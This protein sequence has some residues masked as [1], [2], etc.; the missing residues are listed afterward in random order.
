MPHRPRRR[1]FAPHLWLSCF[2]LAAPL[3]AGVAACSGG[4]GDPLAAKPYDATGQ[5]AYS[6]AD[7][8]RQVDPDK[9]L[10]VT[11]KGSGNKI[12]DVTAT[13]ATGRYVR[14][15]LN[16]DGTQ[17]HSTAAL[18][19]G[20]HYT[21]RVSTENADG[22]QGRQTVGFDTAPGDN[23]LRVRFGPQGGTYGVGQP[24]IAELNRPV[25]DPAARAAV[26]GALRVSSKPA[27]TGAW[28]WVD[29]RTL[30]Y[31]P[32]SYWPANAEIDV[33]SGLQGVR[34][35]GDLYGGAS[36]PLTLH[37]GD[38]VVA[39]T[40]AAAHQLTFSRNGHVERTIP[41]TT[42]KPGFDTR[43]GVKVV[44]D[45]EPFVR[46]RSETI[47]IGHG[48]SDSYDLGVHWATR[49]T[50]SGEYVHAAPWSV[51]SQGSANVSHGCTGMSMDN[52][53]WFYDQVH[54]GD[55]VQVVNSHGRTMEP[56]GNGFGDWN[57]DWRQWLAGSALHGKGGRSGPDATSYGQP[58]ST[59]R[60][61]PRT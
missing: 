21:V 6:A 26:E 32:R 16:A 8:S 52:A 51:G 41:V 53:H 23:A 17:W 54:R 40:D 55:I 5:I 61:T 3:A 2:A 48:S 15:E 35:Q 24:V 10:T 11:A 44:L 1:R 36:A 31:R 49:V 30:H 13:D 59:A 29:D 9:P 38:R 57:L 27:V 19:A 14:G 34:V 33:A 50:W 39:V 25:T 37:T 45:K 22:A 56:F 43:N 12:T 58:G 60:L 42:G 18:A 47:G 28:H 20:A 4:S 7:G 46:M